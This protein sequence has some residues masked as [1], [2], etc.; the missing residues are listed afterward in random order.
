M[1][2]LYARPLLAAILAVTLVGGP[3]SPAFGQ[4]A[5]QNTQAAPAKTVTP[6]VPS[7][8]RPASTS[9]STTENWS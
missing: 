9:S 6:I 5:Q 1:K 4:E 7:P 2:T 8:I 3:V